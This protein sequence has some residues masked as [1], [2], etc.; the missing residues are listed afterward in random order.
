VLTTA[1]PADQDAIAALVQQHQAGL[2]S[3]LRWLGAAGDVADDLVQDTFVAALTS[4]PVERDPAAT[5]AWLRTVAR[6]LLLRQL[7]TAGRRG[8]AV[9]LDEAA[10]AWE[11]HLGGAD[12]GEAFRAALR[13]CL[14]DL[15]PRQGQA[16]RLRYGDDLPVATVGE[17]M[18]I[19][20][21][22]AE[23]LLH[24][25]RAVLRACIQRRLA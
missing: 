8:R 25:L 6:H 5:A 15:T 3:Y 16:M 24:R 20:A 11:R 17:R 13:A 14:H 9:E 2:R 4:P 10:T 7:R 1:V 12:D 18:G 23:T 22:G 19:G 21:A